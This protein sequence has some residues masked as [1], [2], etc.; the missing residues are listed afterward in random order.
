MSSVIEK[1][2][3]K[4]CEYVESKFVCAGSVHVSADVYSDMHKEFRHYATHPST[5]MRI[6]SIVTSIGQLRVICH[7][8]WPSNS[9]SVGDH[10]L[11]PILNKLG[12][13]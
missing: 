13:M 12:V 8:K 6:K 5:G 1:I 10:P 11:F 9:I 4:A 2:E 7:P 3:A